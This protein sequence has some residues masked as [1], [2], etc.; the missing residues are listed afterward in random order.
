MGIMKR[1]KHFIK[2]K[3]IDIP[4]KQNRVTESDG[5]RTYTRGWTFNGGA[6]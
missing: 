6:D 5:T 3:R 1:Q 4:L 2:G